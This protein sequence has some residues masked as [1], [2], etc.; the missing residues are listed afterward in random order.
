MVRKKLLLSFALACFCFSFPVSA[1]A[2]PDIQVNVD[3]AWVEFDQSPI[4]EKGR[5]L[6]PLRAIFEALGVS[7]RWDEKTG[8]VVAT[9]NGETLELTIGKSSALVGGKRVD[10]DVPGKL[11]NGRTLVPTRFIAQSLGATVRW[12]ESTSTVV[13]ATD[14]DSI[15]NVLGMTDV[16]EY[17]PKELLA[18]YENAGVATLTEIGTGYRLAVSDPRAD[19]ITVKV[20]LNG[21]RV[22]EEKYPVQGGKLTYDLVMEPYR[23][24]PGTLTVVASA[25]SDP[26][27]PPQYWCE[28]SFERYIVIENGEYGFFR[29]RMLDHNIQRTMDLGG[30]VAADRRLFRKGYVPSSADELF[31]QELKTLAKEITRGMDDEYLKFRAIATWV[32]SNIYYDMDSLQSGIS[33]HDNTAESVLDNRRGVCEGYASLTRALLRVSGIP[34]RTVSGYALGV[35][36]NGRWPEGSDFGTNHAWNVAFVDGQW[37]TVDTTWMSKNRYVN[38]NYAQ[39]EPTYHYFDIDL[40]DISNTHR[41]S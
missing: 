3:G 35:G 17:R 13:V 12:E 25:N 14:S 5:T 40:F 4:M 9:R 31:H 27:N 41:M 7:P 37:R 38:G 28:Y 15:P 34:S 18:S 20:D 33:I 16:P 39:K 36:T 30:P 23:N 2:S 6:V 1:I 24:Q 32:A 8:T 29:P 19:F 11:E 22:L 26:H 10:M 21:D